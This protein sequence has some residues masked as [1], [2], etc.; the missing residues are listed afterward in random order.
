MDTFHV[1]VTELVGYAVG[2]RPGSKHQTYAC[3][4]HTPEYRKCSHAMVF[5]DEARH[6]KAR[7]HECKVALTEAPAE[8]LA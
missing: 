7:C 3:I 1:D 2:E 6:D 5:R 8:V 4:E